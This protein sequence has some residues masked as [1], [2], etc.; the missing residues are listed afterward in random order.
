MTQDIEK[1]RQRRD[2]LRNERDV[3]AS[4]AGQGSQVA[5]MQLDGAVARARAAE[6]AYDAALEAR[7][8][9]KR[10]TPHSPRPAL[11]QQRAELLQKRAVRA[12][13]VEQQI[14]TERAR[15][16][17]SWPEHLVQQHLRQTLGIGLHSDR[18]REAQELA[19]LASLDEQL[20]ELDRRATATQP[21][22]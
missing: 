4:Q 15:I 9:P 20:A 21:A 17:T 11:E 2:Q 13:D 3:L 8:R 19:T 14:A 18:K 7:E 5:A 22:A 6:C 12:R 10:V 1:L 16:P